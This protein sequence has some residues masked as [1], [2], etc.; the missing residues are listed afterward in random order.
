MDASSRAAILFFIIVLLLLFGIVLLDQQT[1]T[2]SGSSFGVSISGFQFAGIQSVNASGTTVVVTFTIKDETPIGGTL[3]F[4]TYKLFG[5]GNYIGQ[6]TVGSPVKIPVHGNVGATTDLLLPLSGGLRGT[7][8]YF[9]DGGNVS[10]RARGNATIEESG[11]GSAAVQ[12]NCSSVA[13]SSLISCS[14]VVHAINPL[15]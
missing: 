3:Q 7:W 10:W 13:G 9:L 1:A 8:I 12:F 14:Y 15:S 4:A 11:F 5:D 6:G 2:K